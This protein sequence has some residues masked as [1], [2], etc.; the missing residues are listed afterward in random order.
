MVSSPSDDT[1]QISADDA[2]ID[3]LV[4]GDVHA[5]R[6]ALASGADINAADP[7]SRSS[8]ACALTGAECVYPADSAASHADHHLAAGR[9]PT[10]P[11]R[12]S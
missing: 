2:F 12:C 11:T 4:R 1:R 3:A 9:S 10:G 8:L 7:A 5:A 6:A